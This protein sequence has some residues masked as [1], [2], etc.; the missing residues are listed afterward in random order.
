MDRFGHGVS[1]AWLVRLAELERRFDGPMPAAQLRSA[2]FGSP[3]RAARVA[4]LGQARFLAR[5]IRDAASASDATRPR[6]DELA[7][8]SRQRRQCLSF[9]RS[10]RQQQREAPPTKGGASIDGFPITRS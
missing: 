5:L 9:A 4:A 2:R 6:L 8:Y 3:H 1:Q 7:F 10:M